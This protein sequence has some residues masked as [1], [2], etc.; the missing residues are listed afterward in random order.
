MKIET[1]H[2]AWR[3]A[4]GQIELLQKD[5]RELN[6]THEMANMFGKMHNMLRLKVEALKAAKIPP[7]VKNVPEVMSDPK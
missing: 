7:S 6:R 3:V 2:D 5:N 1:V 4:A